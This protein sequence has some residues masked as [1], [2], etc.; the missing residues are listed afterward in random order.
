MESCPELSLMTH[1][2]PD[3]GQPVR[4]LRGGGHTLRRGEPLQGAL[5]QAAA[6]PRPRPR[7]RRARRRTRLR[8]H[9][10]PQAGA[11]AGGDGAAQTGT[12]NVRHQGGHLEIG[13][14]WQVRQISSTWPLPSKAYGFTVYALCIYMAL[15][16]GP[17]YMHYKKEPPSGHGLSSLTS[18]SLHQL[19]L[20][21]TG[22]SRELLKRRDVENVVENPVET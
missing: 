2:I 6:A 21:H 10:R 22:E 3:L 5:C 17:F 11:H 20:G 9:T 12:G 19:Q 7:T 4:A 8:Q 18:L 14:M 15:A 1:N 16:D 13:R